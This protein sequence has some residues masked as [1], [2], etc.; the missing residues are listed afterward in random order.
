M[1]SPRLSLPA[2]PT[3]YLKSNAVLVHA[4]GG[5]DVACMNAICP[6]GA[7]K[8]SKL[9]T[10][11][12]STLLA[13]RG[14]FPTLANTFRSLLDSSRCA[15]VPSALREKSAGHQHAMPTQITRHLSSRETPNISI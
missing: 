6:F 15:Q 9:S 12:P 2:V 7:P 3:K 13:D 8:H 14:S 1:T 5:P 10:R 11:T 4:K